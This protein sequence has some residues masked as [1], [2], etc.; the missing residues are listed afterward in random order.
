MRFL[1]EIAQGGRRSAVI[2]A[3]SR[4]VRASPFEVRESTGFT[5]TTKSIAGAEYEHGHVRAEEERLAHDDVVEVA[6]R[7]HHGG[8]D[9][10]DDDCAARH[11]A[12]LPPAGGQR[13]F[14]GIMLDSGG[15]G[16]LR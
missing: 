3:S 12:A 5:R 11:G 13:A 7:A 14:A 4:P 15:R 10:A 1:L 2:T 8:A 16:K 6:D 9:E